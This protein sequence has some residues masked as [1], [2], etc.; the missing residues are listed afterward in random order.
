MNAL[1]TPRRLR[2]VVWIHRDGQWGDAPFRVIARHRSHRA[3]VR[4]A[5]AMRKRG[6]LARV[7]PW[8]R[9]SRTVRGWMVAVRRPRKQAPRPQD[10]EI[11]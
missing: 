9:H 10:L 1:R 5:V 7:V 8:P 3:A 2:L 4:R 6:Y 11:Y